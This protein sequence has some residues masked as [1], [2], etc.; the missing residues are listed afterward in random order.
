MHSV[1]RPLAVG[2]AVLAGIAAGTVWGQQ[3]EPAP[4]SFAVAHA[5]SHPF[6]E[7]S[8]FRS[9]DQD[10][11]LSATL[12]VGKALNRIGEDLVYLR[13][14]NGQLVGPT[15]RVK[16]GDTLM[17]D[18]VNRL[19]FEDSLLGGEPNTLL[20]EHNTL[21]GFNVTNLHYHGLHVSPSETG[22]NVLI[23]IGPGQTQ[24][25]RF[26]IPKDHPAGT[27]WYHPHRHGS[28]AAQVSSGMA[29]ALIIEGGLDTVPEI[30]NAR[31][32]IWVLQQAP[33]VQDYTDP[34]TKQKVGMIEA[35]NAQT[36]YAPNAMD[37]LKR[38]T[39]V[40]GV[41]LPVVR[42]R[43]G[44]VERWRL[45]DT[46]TVD[47]IQLKLVKAQLIKAGSDVNVVSWGDGSGVPLSGKKSLIIVGP[48][49]KGQLHIRTFDD[50]GNRVM[51]TDETKLPGTQATAIATLKQ[52][53]L[54]WLP[55]HVLTDAEKAQVITELTSIV[56]QIPLKGPDPLPLVRDRRRRPPAGQ[57]D[58]AGPGRAL[59]GLSIRRA[60]P[61]LRR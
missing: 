33:Y 49:N 46:G 8:E 56:S 51:D 4:Q 2:W 24:Q 31:E 20:G 41:V 35:K 40:N 54:G 13:S 15:L 18:L 26:R 30:M 38:F 50:V 52:Q 44:E 29:G 57:D 22:D 7:P 42:M 61:G 59:A 25:F 23:D 3:D 19:P 45:I 16:P 27:F 58:Q 43:P 36:M 32:R 17:L 11:I 34:V 10:S 14:Y 48:D 47:Q 6:Q 21:H 12:S 28:T 60:G 39:T 37:T 9:R 53:L 1:I 55:P 5:A